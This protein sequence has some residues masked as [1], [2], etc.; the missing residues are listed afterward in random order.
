MSV[1]FLLSE[2]QVK[3]MKRIAEMPD[4]SQVVRT[5]PR[6][7][8]HLLNPVT[9]RWVLVTAAGRIVQ[10]QDAH[11]FTL[12]YFISNVILQHWLMCVLWQVFHQHDSSENV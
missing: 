7:K 6:I 8:K 2:P 3:F 1:C 4:L 5:L 11:S 10:V 9:M 12:L